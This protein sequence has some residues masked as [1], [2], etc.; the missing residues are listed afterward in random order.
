LAGKE[1]SPDWLFRTVRKDRQVRWLQLSCRRI[2]YGDQLAVQA[3]LADVTDRIVAERALAESE[4]RFRDIFQ[5]S[6]VGLYRTTPDGRIL[7]AN[8]ATMTMLGYTS[9]DELAR[10]N[11]EREGFEPDYP[12]SEFRRRIEADGQV[13]GLESQWVRSDGKTL[14]VRESARAIRDEQGNVLCYEG[15]VEDITEL[16]KSEEELADERNKLGAI[17]ETMESGVTIRDTDYTLTYQ[18]KCS[19]DRVGDHV[20]EKCYRVFGGIDRVC[21]GC[22]VELALEDGKPHGALRTVELSSGEVTHWHNV[23]SPIRDAKGKIVSCLEVNMEITELVRTQES[24]RESEGTFR[25]AMEATNDALWDWDLATNEVY[26]NPRHATMLGYEPCELTASHD[27]WEKRIHPDDRPSVFEIVDS[28]LT[29]ESDSFEMEYRLRTKS[30]DY[31]WVLGRGRVVGRSDDGAPARMIGTNI[32]ITERKLAEDRLSGALAWQEAMFEGARDAVLIT[33][34]DSKFVMVNRRAC[35]LTGYSKRELLEMRIPDLHAVQD[36]TAYN[37]YHDRIMSGEEVVSEARLLRKDGTKIDTEFS[38]RRVCIS[39]EVYMHTIARDITER[40]RAEGALHESENRLALAIECAGLGLWDQ[41]FETGE[42]NRNENWSTM[43]EYEPDEIGCDKESYRQ[44]LHPDDLPRFEQC[45]GDHETGLTDIF[46]MEHRMRAKS[47]DWRW[48]HNFGRIISRD[49]QGIPLRALGVHMDI[50]ERKKAEQVLKSRARLNRIILDAMPNVAMLIRPHTREV[51]A[52]NERAA[53]AGVAPGKRC[54]E[55]WSGKDEPCSL[56]RAPLVWKTGRPQQCEVEE[57]DLVWDAHW[58]PVSDNLYMYYAYDITERKKTEA[59]LVENQK[60]LKAMASRI[61]RAE[62]RERHRIAV[63]LHDDIC[64]KLVLTKLA[65]ESSLDLISSTDASKLVETA[66][67]AIGEA[68]EEADS[69]TFALSNPVLRELGFEAA[70]E[71]YLSEEI[72]RKHGIAFEFEN[73]GQS[74]VLPAEI[75]TCLFRVTRELLTNVVKHARARAIRV[76]V[77]NNDGRICVTIQDDGAGFEVAEVGSE[78]SKTGRFG[79]FSVREQLE[80]LGGQL[81]IE[82]RPEQG[83][84][85]TVV[86][87]LRNKSSV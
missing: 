26:R 81:D 30:G 17:L 83:T 44:L 11:L 20:G 51:V 1:L 87:P 48:I 8:K 60:K 16:R 31:I 46:D 49:A 23:A 78:S 57:R 53:Q 67:G 25:L 52:C 24:L 22:P 10:R 43:L 40:K 9:L 34:A 18:N 80:H 56:C 6:V 69:L 32:D 77:R 71:K 5:N 61:L 4:E 33:D 66:C 74:N 76:V 21:D 59:R 3:I 84:T 45:A 19:V 50:T 35:E 64:Q 79:L 65:L 58:V 39:D 82:S 36:L 85:A 42:I 68:I 70:L 62:D 37:L 14:F 2:T 15:T 54:F 41:D 55:A 12:R 28:I 38:N 47:G 63:G 86:V 29:G 7:M 27:E 72:R 75:K 73:D 13:I